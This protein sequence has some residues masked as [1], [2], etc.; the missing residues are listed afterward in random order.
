VLA[1]LAV[2]WTAAARAEAPNADTLRA[3]LRTANPGEEAYLTYV[4]TLVAQGRLPVE[5]VESTFLWARRK[6]YPKKFQYFKFALITRASQ[7]GITLPQET[8]ALTG[9]IRG[10]VLARIL[11]VDLPVPDVTVTL[12]GT[13]REA[14]TDAKGEFTFREVPFG[15]YTLR[16]KGVV[17]L[18]ARSASAQ[19]I[20]PSPPPST[21]PVLVT[22]ELK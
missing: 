4:A 9:T 13:R 5:L 16:A 14:T 19:V 18:L 1:V 17:A 8:P 10:R 2:G 6:P 21:D 3:G 15:R 12:E 7:I 11:L 20:L 22:L